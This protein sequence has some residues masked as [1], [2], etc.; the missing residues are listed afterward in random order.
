A[1]PHLLHAAQPGDSAPMGGFYNPWLV[2]LSVIVAVLA[3]FAAFAVID[4]IRASPAPHPTG[5]TLW[6]AA[7]AV[8]LGSGIWAMH[9][10]GMLA[11]E[12]PVPVHYD[13]RFTLA[14]I[15]PAVLMSG[16]AIA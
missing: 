1:L 5:S 14:S 13:F 11:F 12:L 8:A 7:G 3:A 15:V 4:R 10:I 9:F 16:A 6:I 2:G